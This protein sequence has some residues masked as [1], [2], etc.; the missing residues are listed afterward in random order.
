M[1]FQD[2][3]AN[4][5]SS[6]LMLLMITLC[7]LFLLN[8]AMDLMLSNNFVNDQY[9][10]LS[11]EK[12]ALNYEKKSLE[13]DLDKLYLDRAEGANESLQSSNVKKIELIKKLSRWS[14]L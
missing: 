8:Q 13:V 5:I 1:I 10:Q 7:S 12:M 3:S 14:E 2:N 11:Q 9:T 6:P 4:Q